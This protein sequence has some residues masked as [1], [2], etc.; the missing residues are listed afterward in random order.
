MLM[1][2]VSCVTFSKALASGDLEAAE[3]AFESIEKRHERKNAALDLAIAFKNEGNLNKAEQY[4]GKSYLNEKEQIL[5]LATAAVE[6]EAYEESI[7]YLLKLEDSKNQLVL[8]RNKLILKDFEDAAKLYHQELEGSD[9]SFHKTAVRILLQN[10]MD[11]KALAHM[12]ALGIPAKDFIAVKARMIL[13]LPLVSHLSK[14]TKDNFGALDYTQMAILDDRVI[15]G[16]HKNDR[17]RIY[18]VNTG[19]KILQHNFIF[20]YFDI[21]NKGT[22]EIVAIESDSSIVIAKQGSLSKWSFP[23][24]DA[25]LEN[26]S[27]ID[28]VIECVELA[29]PMSE[30]YLAFGAKIKAKG[31]NYGSVILLD[32][33]TLEELKRIDLENS[34]STIAVSPN[35]QLIAADTDDKL[36]VLNAASGKIVTEL[37]CKNPES[38]KAR[39]TVSLAFSPD[40][41]YLTQGTSSG[42]LVLYKVADEGLEEVDAKLLFFGHEYN[43]VRDIKF[44]SNGWIYAAAE[45]SGNITVLDLVDDKL[46]KVMTFYKHINTTFGLL[47]Q[48]SGDKLFS[49]S[50]DETVNSW[51]VGKYK[52]AI[53]LLRTS[54]LS[55][56]VSERILS[57]AFYRDAIII[58]YK[59]NPDQ[60]PVGIGID[61]SVEGMQ[62]SAAE[63][64]DMAS[65]IRRDEI[66]IAELQR[67]ALYYAEIGTDQE[68]IEKIE[69]DL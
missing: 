1:L 19:N 46:V 60:M 6:L 39:M 37:A 40:N 33:K 22:E 59:N 8:Y 43:F 32:T 47:Q 35:G 52:R 64:E 36:T 38:G 25:V 53:E 12:E 56:E 66:M 63:L 18:D 57:E 55:N 21:V 13:Q 34:I 3:S 58:K 2:C 26:T 69:T 7:K 67:M 14:L 17:L 5:W 65:R 28:D 41:Q 44:S 11:D 27:S 49:I 61:L 23:D 45:G 15:L 62:E 54:D 20:T 24:N 51:N 50:S 29:V 4:I 42:E 9:E 68:W 10:D 30:E 48:K 31:K 16:G